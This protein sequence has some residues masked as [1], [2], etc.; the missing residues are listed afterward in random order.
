VALCAL[1]P[2]QQTLPYGLQDRD[3]AVA[4][5][6]YGP[7]SWRYEW[8]RDNRPHPYGVVCSPSVGLYEWR[9]QRIKRFVKPTAK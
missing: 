6:Q 3:E 9:V 2:D 8:T 7:D 5:G 4:G 1:D